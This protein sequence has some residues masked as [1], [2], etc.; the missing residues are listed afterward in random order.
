MRVATSRTSRVRD[1]DRLVL[2]ARRLGPVELGDPLGDELHILRRRPRDDPLAFRL[3]DQ[4]DGKLA[5]S[6]DHRVVAEPAHTAAVEPVAPEEEPR[7]PSR[8]RPP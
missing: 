1:R 7:E 3:G 8:D 4:H 6:H 2:L 5:G